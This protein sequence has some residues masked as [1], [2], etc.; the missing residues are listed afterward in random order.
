MVSRQAVQR[1]DG[2]VVRGPT[3]GRRIALVFTRARVRRGRRHDA[4]WS[5]DE[6]LGTLAARGYSFVR[7]DTLLP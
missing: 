5:A 2:G 3:E 6:L 4:R 7:V 1:I